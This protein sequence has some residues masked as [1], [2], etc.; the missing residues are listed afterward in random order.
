MWICVCHKERSVIL[1]WCLRTEVIIFALLFWSKLNKCY[2][3]SDDDDDDDENDENDGEEDEIHD[4]DD[5]GDDNIEEVYMP[6]FINL[7]QKWKMEHTRMRERER[8]RGGVWGCLCV[9]VWNIE[10]EWRLSKTE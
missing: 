8:E 3:W 5:D 9:C 10:V 7:G 2:Q 6:Y 4:D 1:K